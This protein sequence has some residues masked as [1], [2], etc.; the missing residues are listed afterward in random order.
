[1]G[2]DPTWSGAFELGEALAR[3]ELSSRELL[4]HQ[5][6]RI[7]RLDPGLNAVVTRDLEGARAAAA[8]ADVAL[9]R[10]E[11]RGP[12]HGVAITFKDTLETAGL[13]TT[14]GYPPLASHVP[15]ADAT[16]V[17]RLRA[18]GA[19]VL[20]KTNVPLLA[21]DAQTY[22]AIFGV[23]R[24][25]WDA[26]RTPGGSSGGAAAALAA[27]L[28][29]L[30]VG[31][32]IGGSIRT[33][34]HWCG[35]Y[36]HKPT[37]G[38]VPLRGHIPG[39]PGTLA[40]PDLAVAGP[41]A[42]T[43]RDL[44]RALE[45]LAGPLPDRAAGW[46]L[47]LPAPRRARLADWRVAAWLDDPSGPVDPAVRACLQQAVD[48]LRAAG[49]HVDE[50]ARP[51]LSLAQVEERYLQLL[52]SVLFAGIPPDTFQKLLETAAA[53]PPGAPEALVRA[54]R[55]GT[56]RHRDWLSANE[57]R[58]HVRARMAEFFQEFDLL[59]MPVN[60]LPAIPHDPS[61]PMLARRLRIGGAE[62]SYLELFRWIALATLALLP[63]TAAP[64][65]RTP[66]GLPVGIQIVGPYLEDRSCLELAARLEE[67]LGG[68]VPPPGF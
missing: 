34:C 60:P 56:L 54:A 1:M 18:A 51:A 32:D 31:S 57:A 19:I 45:L 43:P 3:G 24:N 21:G 47:A 53:P 9:A 55:G 6:R 50:G 4:E 61:E 65:G 29:P 41:M 23:T 67:V 8:A 13:R 2:I 25:P 5:I 37:H 64:V 33:P 52:F 35:V 62:A 26:A 30:E 49:V 59:L 42:R 38:I 27:G 10:G 44:A 17:A 7:E 16:V 28:T 63:A 48:A 36:G 40:E 14:A 66:E 15:S 68:F 46:R 22:N 39:P 11:R 58:E 12:L 20:G